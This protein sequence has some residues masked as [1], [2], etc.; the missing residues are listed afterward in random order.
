VALVREGDYP[1]YILPKGR[2]EPGESLVQAAIR[3]IAEEA[4]LTGLEYLG[5]LGTQ[6]RLNYGKNAWKVI[7][8]FLFQ[9]ERLSGSPTDL[10]HDY[11][12]EWYPID[13][14]PDMFWPEQKE[15]IDTNR[16]KI[17]ALVKSRAS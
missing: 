13:H 10:S 2:V 14:L 12:C 11:R 6:E 16:G 3:E 15:L 7:H 9:T 1:A 4:G 8:Y 5:Y 17:E